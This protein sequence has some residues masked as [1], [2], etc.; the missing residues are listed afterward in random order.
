MTKLYSQKVIH[1]CCALQL[2]ETFYTL[3]KEFHVMI[4]KNRALNSR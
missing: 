1:I 3:K 4:I 2:H